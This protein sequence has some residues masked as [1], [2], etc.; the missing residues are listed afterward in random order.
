MKK[1]L[2]IAC[3]LFLG[4]NANAQS[5]LN[6]IKQKVGERLNE[7]VGENHKI[8]YKKYETTWYERGMGISGTGSK[9]SWINSYQITDVQSNGN[10]II[11][12]GTYNVASGWEGKDSKS[13]GFEAKCKKIL[14]DYEVIK[15]VYITNGERYCYYPPTNCSGL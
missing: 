3:I 4:I 5:Q 9:S 12:T 8:D 11:V 7:Y 10:I 14:D 2:I 1:I 15:I 6:Y 13:L